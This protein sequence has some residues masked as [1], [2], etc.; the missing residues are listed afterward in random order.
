MRQTSLM[1]LIV[2]AA[3]VGAVSP[4]LGLSHF[5]RQGSSVSR[6]AALRAASA[7]FTSALLFDCDG[8]LVETEELHRTA[9]NE[10][11]PALFQIVCALVSSENLLC[12]PAVQAFKAF[13]LEINNEPVEWSVQY[14]DRL[15]NT[16]G[17]GKPK[18]KYH[19]TQEARRTRVHQTNAR[20][21]TGFGAL[22]SVRSSPQTASNL[23]LGLHR[24]GN[25]PLS[26]AR[27]ARG[28]RRLTRPRACL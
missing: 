20:M 24:L 14:Y 2:S 16:V 4:T 13:G 27:G 1:L 11:G 6:H 19:F 26:K 22:E 25:G 3:V 15:Q 18:M 17:G 8:V 5:R 21:G 7:P 12:L 23:P 28:R 9:Y 10:V